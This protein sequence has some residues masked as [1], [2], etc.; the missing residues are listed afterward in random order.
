[1]PTSKDGFVY[2]DGEPTPQSLVG[3]LARLFQSLE[4]DPLKA[5]KNQPTF[6]A[7]QTAMDKLTSENGED[8]T[9]N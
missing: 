8:D 9:T 5:K 4:S 1:M 2:P 3:Y 7:I 6:A